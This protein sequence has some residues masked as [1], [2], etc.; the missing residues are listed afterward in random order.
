ML[1]DSLTIALVGS[2]LLCSDD[3]AFGQQN[4]LGMRA[5][6]SIV[7]AST[8]RFLDDAFGNAAN[9]GGRE[10]IARHARTTQTRANAD[11]YRPRGLAAL[12]GETRPDGRRVR[13]LGSA[14][15]VH[16][17]LGK[18]NAADRCPGPNKRDV[19]AP[20]T[21]VLAGSLQSFLYECNADCNVPKSLHENDHAE[22]RWGEERS[23]EGEDRHNAECRCHAEDTDPHD[24]PGST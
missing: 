19:Q 13:A 9:E 4:P 12:I 14:V 3:P 6:I 24:D 22:N 10:A 23:T 17:R 5:Y 18:R 7:S 2:A 15:E 1:A 16:V 21:S 11:A 20:V 8:T